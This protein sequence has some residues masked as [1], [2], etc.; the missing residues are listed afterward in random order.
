MLSDN[1]RN[2][3]ET[4]LC[5]ILSRIGALK[6][7]AFKLASGKISSY[8]IDLRIVP[9]FPEAFRNICKMYSK[10]V[11]GDIGTRSFDRIAGVPIASIPFSSLV[12]YQLK[13]PF[14][15]IRSEAKSH[16]RR[17][18]VEGILEPR[19]R[20]LV[21]DDLITTGGS[22]K[23]VVAAIRAEGGL[24][25][26]VAVLINREEGGTENLA[27]IGVKLHYLLKASESAKKLY[28]IGVISEDQLQAVLSQL[29]K[30]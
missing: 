20:V 24:V 21:I 26:N 10:L 25:T 12:A 30:K 14:F 5:Q 2:T 15:Y 1:E 11:S 8:Y 4:E 6:F 9:S 16:G 29:K 28:E 13:K 19:D 27:E 7:G 3:I 18:R 22:V 23:E 17:R